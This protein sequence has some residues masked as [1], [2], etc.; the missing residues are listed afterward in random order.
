MPLYDY[1]S[2]NG[3]RI[4]RFYRM[5]DDKPERITEGG[6][7]YAR[8]YSMPAISVSAGHGVEPGGGSILPVSRTV[9][10][11]KDRIV[12]TERVGRERVN[13]HSDGMRTDGRGRP[14]VENRKDRDRV[15]N[16]AMGNG[17]TFNN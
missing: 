9:G 16:W 6:I 11:R 13:T 14:I 3:N 2:A 8:V 10:L 4:E 1:E 12:K 15:K 17:F 7:T 5:N